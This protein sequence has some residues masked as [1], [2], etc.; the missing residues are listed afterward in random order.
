MPDFIQLP[1]Q[2]LGQQQDAHIAFLFGAISRA[3][4]HHCL[5]LRPA[6]V[7]SC[8]QGFRALDL[9]WHRLG[10]DTIAKRVMI[11]AQAVFLAATNA[12]AVQQIMVSA[13][14][15]KIPI[16]LGNQIAVLKL[17]ISPPFAADKQLSEDL[18]AGGH[19]RQFF[20]IAKANMPRPGRM[21]NAIIRTT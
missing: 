12:Q 18:I 16:G 7:Q 8:L 1:G 13:V 9:G 6:A 3:L 15:L 14:D 4:A 21:M 20:E 19:P 11:L 10:D 17:I 5:E 2:G